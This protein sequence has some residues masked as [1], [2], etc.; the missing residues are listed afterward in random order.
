LLIQVE[1]KQIWLSGRETCNRSYTSYSPEFVFS[2]TY[3]KENL[4][5]IGCGISC[6]I[7]SSIILRHR[8]TFY[9]LQVISPTTKFNIKKF[10]MMLALRLCF[11]QISEQTATFALHNANG[12]VSYNQGGK[13]LLCG[14]VSVL[15]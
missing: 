14:T 5:N 7:I 6:K 1:D 11:V 15:T 4:L 12:L 10:Y 8:L 13:C 9:N 3:S 2:T